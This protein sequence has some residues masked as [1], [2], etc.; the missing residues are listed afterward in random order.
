MPLPLIPLL[1]AGAA[2]A[3][4]AVA[5]K[6]GYDSYNN[7]K[8]TK[9]LAEALQSKYKRAY[10]N[11]EE[12]RDVVNASFEAYGLLKL[13]I[14]DGSM[15]SFIETFKQIKNVQFKDEVVQDVLVT[16]RD[17]EG[18]V[19]EIEKQVCVC[20]RCIKMIFFLVSENPPTPRKN[21]E[22]PETTVPTPHYYVMAR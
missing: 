5:G 6:K 13:Q 15:K 22:V 3:S 20:T 14:L 18:F 17:V 12:K 2:A 10:N 1:V 9:E 11:F 8:E 16:N 21:H 19:L 7:M 4:A